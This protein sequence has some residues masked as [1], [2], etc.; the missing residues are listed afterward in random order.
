MTHQTLSLKKYWK[1][2]P[3]TLSCEK[4]NIVAVVKTK[5]Q[6]VLRKLQLAYEQIYRE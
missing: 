2:F 5:M 1:L 3:A 6:L 4:K